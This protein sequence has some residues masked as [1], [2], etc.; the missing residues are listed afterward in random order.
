V[1]DC[2]HA[3]ASC[4][5]GF[6]PSGEVAWRAEG[7][8]LACRTAPFCPRLRFAPR[9]RARARR[10]H[11]RPA[12]A[13]GRGGGGLVLP[14]RGVCAAHCSTRCAGRFGRGRV[15][16][17]A[18]RR[19]YAP[20]LVSKPLSSHAFCFPCFF[21]WRQASL[22]ASTF[23]S[24]SPSRW[25]P[26]WPPTAPRATRCGGG[27]QNQAVAFPIGAALGMGIR[28]PHVTLCMCA[29]FLGLCAREGAGG[30]GHS[31]AAGAESRR[32]PSGAA[33]PPSV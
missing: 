29:I 33:A 2:K 31:L 7:A 8:A 18:A 30:G 23:C 16:H 13:R 32:P 21:V 4:T 10:R 17:R 24:G 26:A 25:S 11:S 28:V 14:G 6:S 27:L 19:R 5:S 20:W 22:R 15:G 3:R 9:R 12:R 1:K